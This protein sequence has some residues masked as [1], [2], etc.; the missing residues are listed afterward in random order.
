MAAFLETGQSVAAQR[1][2][3]AFLFNK[4]LDGIGDLESTVSKI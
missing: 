4:R 1:I 3:E 2:K